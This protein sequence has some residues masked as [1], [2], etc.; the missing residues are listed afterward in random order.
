MSDKEAD[1]QGIL[2]RALEVTCTSCGSTQSSRDDT[3]SACGAVLPEDE[4]EP[5]FS[6]MSEAPEAAELPPGVLKIT[7]LEK[8][9]NFIALRKAGTIPEGGVSET[10][11]REIMTKLKFVGDSGVKVFESAPARAKFGPLKGE[12]KAAAELMNR[13]FIRLLGGVK[14]METYLDKRDAAELKAG[15]AE[16]E[17]GFVDIDTAQHMAA[18]A[19]DKERGA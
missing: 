1:L 6:M 7:P 9:K 16:A 5:S 10:E 14:R 2:S 12:G 15:L 18:A 19:R 8:S 11:F 17:G 4:D 13:G 3:C